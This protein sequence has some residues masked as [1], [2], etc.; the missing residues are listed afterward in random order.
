MLHFLRYGL[1]LMPRAEY[2]FEAVDFGSV[3]H[4]VLELFERSLKEDGISLRTLS[5]EEMEQRLWDAFSVLTKEYG[6]TILY[7]SARNER[8][9]RQMHRLLLR[10]VRTMQYQ[11]Q[12]GSFEPA[13]FEQKFRMKGVFPLVGKIDRI[14]IRQ[15]RRCG[16]S[17]GYGL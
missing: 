9:I 1:E 11:M 16:L 12:K 10:S 17:E 15:G 5:E 14:D 6:E 4:G 2:T 13:Y 7:S 3:Y 8:R